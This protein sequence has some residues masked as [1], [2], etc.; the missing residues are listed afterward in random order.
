MQSS[1]S[2][3]RNLLLTFLISILVIG[4]EKAPEQNND[5]DP[6]TRPG[7]SQNG[8]EAS[9]DSEALRKDIL[10]LEHP[11]EERL[12]WGII[13]G[14]VSETEDQLEIIRKELKKF[15]PEKILG[16]DVR[17]HM[18]L[19]DSYSSKLMCAGEIMHHNCPNFNFEEFRCWIILHGKETYHEAK[20]NPNSLIQHFGP[21]ENC[22]SSAM[23]HQVA[24]EVLRE[25]HDLELSSHIDKVKF[26]FYT[27]DYPKLSNDWSTDRPQS[28]RS[29]C[30]QLFDACW[31]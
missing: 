23:L 18:L 3:M 7:I 27:E 10:T 8:N 11:M 5:S 14:S 4:C 26:P 9:S 2:R 19:H 20:S 21:E 13:D 12:F 17:M 29:H 6:Y 30:P 16:F 24:A 25:V 15:S 31:Q 1:Q 28:M 22:Y